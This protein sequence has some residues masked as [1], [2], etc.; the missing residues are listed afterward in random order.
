MKVGVCEC[1][2]AMEE[3]T[4]VEDD[5]IPIC[6]LGYER[7]KSSVIRWSWD[8]NKR[9]GKQCDGEVTYEQRERR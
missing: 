7:G 5:R 8:K 3:A 1:I 2:W 9:K 6:C 4:E